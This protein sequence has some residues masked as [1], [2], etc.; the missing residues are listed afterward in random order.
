MSVKPYYNMPFALKKEQREW[1]TGLAESRETH[2]FTLVDH[3]RDIGATTALVH[4]AYNY[5]FNFD[6]EGRVMYLNQGSFAGFSSN[7]PNND[8]IL[9]ST[10]SSIRYIPTDVVLLIID[11]CRTTDDLKA[12][13]ITHCYRS[14][15]KIQTIVALSENSITGWKSELNRQKAPFNVKKWK[16]S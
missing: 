14:P 16:W 10:A 8:N 12:D 5:N 11:N 15:R 1:L 9:F 7:F 3:A 6:K 2:P 4:Y 13:L